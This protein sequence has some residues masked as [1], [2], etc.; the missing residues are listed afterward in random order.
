MYLLVSGKP[1][2]SCIGMPIL[3]SGSQPLYDF[4]A[5]R[6]AF[7]EFVAEWESGK[8]PKSQWSHAAHVAIGASYAVQFPGAA[9]RRIRDGILRYNKAVGTLESDRSG[10]HETLTRLWS[11]VLANVTNSFSDHWEAARYAVEQLG[12]ERDLHCLYYSFDVVR[13][14][15]A[16]R[17]WIPPDLEGPY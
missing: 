3:H 12:E 11:I 14:A 17:T 6:K 9:F 16:R 10:Y 13:N 1:E 7:E 2:L 8:L 4:L 15:E 5:S